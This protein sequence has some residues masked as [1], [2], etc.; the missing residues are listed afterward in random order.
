M[1]HTVYLSL[2]TNEGN[3]IKNLQQAINTINHKI[4]TIKKSSSIYKTTSWGF[5]GNDF[6][7][8][9]VKV[10]TNQSPKNVLTTLLSI[11][12]E[13]GRKRNPEKGY[14]NR[15]IDIDILLF[16]DKIIV[17]KT[18]VIPHSKMLERK[19]VMVPLV[20]IAPEKMHPIEKKELYKCLKKCPD[21][22]EIIKISEKITHPISLP[23]NNTNSLK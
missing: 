19:F 20:E 21:T 12:K 9:C 17:S 16:N 1:K 2:G 8:M 10:S 14:Q 6:L 22:S 13:L 15:N 4:G 3:K 18:L 11:E 7:N 5:S 23:K